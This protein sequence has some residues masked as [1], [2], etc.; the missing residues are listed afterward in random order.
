MKMG[1]D[2][3]DVLQIEIK[4]FGNVNSYKEFAD[5]VFGLDNPTR[6]KA[7]GINKYFGPK[8]MEIYFDKLNILTTNLGTNE[9]LT[10]LSIY[11]DEGISY[12]I[13][14]IANRLSKE[15]LSEGERLKIV[16]SA[17]LVDAQRR[18]S[19]LAEKIGGVSIPLINNSWELGTHSLILLDRGRLN[20]QQQL[21]FRGVLDQDLIQLDQQVCPMLRTGKDSQGRDAYGPV[22]MVFKSEVINNPNI[23]DAVGVLA[24]QPTEANYQRVIDAYRSNGFQFL[25]EQAESG[26]KSILR[27]ML[28]LG[29]NFGE[30]MEKLHKDYLN[31]NV[32][33]SPFLATSDSLDKASI[34]S[35]G[36]GMILVMKVPPERT[37]K[38]SLTA[39]EEVFVFGRINKEDIVA[40]I[41]INRISKDEIDRYEKWKKWG[42]CEKEIREILTN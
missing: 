11:D 22:G 24:K 41:P 34:F 19:V 42:N 20:N 23:S 39:E 32:G 36:T 12:D 3:Q 27:G 29:D 1:L 17:W 25:A 18:S 33:H 4:N 16:Q 14:Q 31:G 5:L 7:I 38:F 6:I 15:G 28:V 13:D 10:K 40:V 8:P 21:L 30:S 2:Q 35:Q 26:L 9:T 37:K